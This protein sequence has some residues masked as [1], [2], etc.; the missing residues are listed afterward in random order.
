MKK[1]RKKAI[2]QIVNSLLDDK[3]IQIKECEEEIY[4]YLDSILFVSLIIK[5]EEEFKINLSDEDFIMDKFSTI[6]KIDNLI[7]KYLSIS[8]C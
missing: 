5:L 3:N 1:T 8:D 4:N 2:L 7:E 6:N